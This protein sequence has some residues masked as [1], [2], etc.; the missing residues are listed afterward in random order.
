MTNVRFSNDR[1]RVI[2][3]G[4]EDHAVFQWRF[5]ATG[6][7]DDDLPDHYN[8]NHSHLFTQ[9][10]ERKFRKNSCLFYE[11]NSCWVFCDDLKVR[12]FCF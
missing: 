5:F 11:M 10:S 9:V 2:S 1:H 8:G 6:E 3:T 7:G 4:G 12:E